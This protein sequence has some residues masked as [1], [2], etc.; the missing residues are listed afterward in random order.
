M[1]TTKQVPAE[2]PLQQPQHAEAAAIERAPLPLRPPSKAEMSIVTIVSLGLIVW[3]G[4]FA[5]R[6]TNMWLVIL[7]AFVVFL[8]FLGRW[9]CG[10][11]AGILIGD[12][13]LMSLS[14]FQMVLWTILI[15][16]AYMAMVLYRLRTGV[17]DPLTIGFDW[18]LWALMGISTTSMIGSPLLLGNKTQKQARPDAIKK[19]ESQLRETF[20]GTNTVGT[21]YANKSIQDASLCDI[22][23]GDEVG[24]TRFI[25]VAK[26]QMFF[27]TLVTL[28]AYGA[29]LYTML[30]GTDY[31]SMPLVSDGLVALLGISHAG[32]LASKVSDHTETN[33]HTETK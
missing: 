18:H 2:A 31:S 22:F 25:D 33:G 24:N 15:L 9:I 20:D 32:Y 1:A 3:A 7:V 6:A 4:V 19:A 16:S 13:N 30:K 26:V 10:R 8:L 11:P 23:Q 27:F 28:A 14:R 21:L 17:K 29:A 12:R 5:A